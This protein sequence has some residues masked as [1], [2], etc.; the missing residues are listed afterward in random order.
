VPDVIDLCP[1]DP[2]SVAGYRVLSR[3]GAGRQGVVFLAATSSGE[4]V[5]IKCLLPGPEETLARVQFAKEVA[6]ARL[7]APFC[8]A[9]VID[10]QVDGDSPF[11]VS[12]FIAGSSLQQE[13]ERTGPILGTALQRIAIGTATALAAIHQAGVVHRDFTP[14]NV[15]ISPDGPRVIDFGIARDLATEMTASS[16][17][18]G[19]PA[20]MSPEQLR[21]EAVGPATDMFAWASVITYAATERAP[22]DAGHV[23]AVM[24]RIKSG[25]PDLSRV[26][27]DLVGV[28]RQCLEKDP[29]RRPTAQQVLA[30]LLGRPGEQPDQPDPSLVLAEATALVRSGD[31]EEPLKPVWGSPSAEPPVPPSGPEEAPP[32][33]RPRRERSQPKSFPPRP[34]GAAVVL[35]IALVGAAVFGATFPGLPWNRDAGALTTAQIAGAENRS[36]V[37]DDQTSAEAAVAAALAGLNTPTT[38][39]PGTSSA[40]PAAGGTIPKSFA[41]TWKGRIV[42]MG[43]PGDGLAVQITLKAGSPSGQVKIP[44]LGCSGS[45][46][47]VLA[48]VT[49]L[50]MEQEINQDPKG[51]CAK[52]SRVYLT[53]GGFI[54]AGDLRFTII[55]DGKPG[56]TGSG[57]LAK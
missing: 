48:L 36:A 25:S 15:M 30:Q 50:T 17:V 35:A 20:Y 47:L 5:A 45:L 38:A 6:A 16:L 23:A 29:A 41:G 28:L 32:L 56:R 40:A 43:D 33:Q 19:T 11:V 44:E 34:V 9:Q 1:G 24:Y 10:A 27:N 12:E 37:P 26:P 4:L 31:S 55:D 21:A 2:E 3:L 49:S 39:D 7:V 46:N 18:F 51:Q 42:I 52:Q 54:D 13:V 57:L 14:A 8:T 53:F 22:F